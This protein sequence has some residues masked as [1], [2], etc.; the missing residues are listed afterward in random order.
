LKTWA[1]RVGADFV[2]GRE[3]GDPGA[4]S[5]DALTAAKARE[6]DVVLFDTA[7]RLHTK[8]NLMDE[9]VR[10]HKVMK[11]VIPEAPHEIWLVIDGTLGQ[12][13]VQQAREFSKAL[14]VTGVVVTKLDG[15]A[16]GGAVFSIVNELKLPIRYIG[17]GEKAEDLLPFE[18]K[19][20][21]EAILNPKSV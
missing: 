3:G 6:V 7:G 11:K 18:P 19:P 4:V 21:V 12:N 16:K 17:L 2:T 20:F 5:F 15:T 13:S 10:V 14:E 9:L 8:T 1:E